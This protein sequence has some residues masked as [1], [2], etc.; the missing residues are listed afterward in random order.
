[1]T[2]FLQPGTIVRKHGERRFITIEDYVSAEEAEDG[3][4]FYWANSPHGFN[5]VTLEPHEFEVVMTA[6]QAKARKPPTVEEVAAALASSALDSYDD[7][8]ITESYRES[9]GFEVG[10]ET[11]DGLRFEAEIKVVW[12]QEVME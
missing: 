9:G 5:D 4:P 10:G 2:D 7:F 1:V 6:E 8:E 12:V 3:K 11:H